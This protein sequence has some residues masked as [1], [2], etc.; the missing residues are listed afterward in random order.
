[1]TLSLYIHIPFCRHRCAYCDFNT[2]TSLGDLKAEYAD[3]VCAELAQVAGGEKRPYH[4][5]F[6]GGGTPSLM[7]PETIRQILQAVDV[8][9]TPTG[10]PE[11][12][13]EANPGTVD[14][15]YLAAVAAAGVNRLS[16][17]VQSAVASELALLERTHDFA[18]AVTAVELA[19]AAGLSNFNLDLIY[20]VPGQT[21]ASW[22][23][24]LEAVLALQPPHLSLYCLTIEP[25]TPMQRWLENG[26]IQLP[27]PDLAAD[28]YDLARDLLAQHGYSHYE[29]S[30]WAK[31]GHECAH[32][33]TY[34][35]DGEYLGLGAG[36]HGHA[37]GV[38][39]QVVKQPRV[40]IK[41]VA[42]GGAP[43]YPLSTAVADHHAISQEEAMTDAIITQLRLLQEGLDLAAFAGRFGRTLDEVYDG[44]VDQLA[45]WDL[46]R[47]R[48]GRLYLTPQAYFLSNQ[49]F[50][51][52]M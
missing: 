15:A 12:T 27:D 36:A 43:G 45:D 23:A 17:G 4:T 47:V 28:Q 6:F 21:L 11:I 32:N 34:W 42:S 16:F 3:A 14:G 8:H 30:N 51:R 33:L 13:M 1:M 44:T 29:I 50:Y 35:R 48:D 10:V 24:S 41:R 5:I 39:Y 40:Y 22:R 9:F 7:P 18:T 25:G 19:R 26:R 37:G 2:Y 46:V 20:G 49:V 38:R 31:P 52:F